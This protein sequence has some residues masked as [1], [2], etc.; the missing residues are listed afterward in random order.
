MDEP[1]PPP[2]TEPTETKTSPTRRPEPVDARFDT[3]EKHVTLVQNQS[4]S[5]FAYFLAFL[6]ALV[7]YIQAA[8]GFW[9]GAWGA[10]KAF[11]WPAF[12]LYDLLRYI[13][14]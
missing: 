8:T 9:V 13:G 14:A 2:E 3:P 10:V 7:Y 4:M 12:V 5:G 6:G 1:T 11:F